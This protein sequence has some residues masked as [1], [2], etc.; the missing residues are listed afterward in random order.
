MR[1]LPVADPRIVRD[2]SRVLPEADLDR[3]NRRAFFGASNCC[4]DAVKRPG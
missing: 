2:M 1:R 4:T 3:A